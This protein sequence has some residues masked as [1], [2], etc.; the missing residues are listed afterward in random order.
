MPEIISVTADPHL[1]LARSLIAEYGQSIADVAACS[2]EHQNFNHELATLPGPYAPPRGRLL[3]AL[4]ND[5]PAGCIA[6]RP[7]DALGPQVCE[8]KRLYVR[9]AF[10][11][12]GLGRQLVN[13]LLDE[14]RSLGYRL[15]KLDTDTDAKFTAAIALYRSLGFTECERYN[16]DP[17]PKTLWFER[18]L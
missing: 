9:P 6:L 14:A 4:I 13:R 11:G 15:M 17:D 1:S 3:L 12:T 16:A 8:M 5:L 7:L 2:L 18:T 10:R